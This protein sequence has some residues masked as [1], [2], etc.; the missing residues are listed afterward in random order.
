AWRERLAE[1]FGHRWRFP[2]IRAQRDG[3]AS[4]TPSTN[5]PAPRKRRPKPSPP[6]PVPPSPFPP[7]PRRDVERQ[8]RGESPNAGRPGPVAVGKRATVS[9]G[10]PD[11]YWKPGKDFPPGI[12][13]MWQPVDIDFPQGVVFLNSEHPVVIEQI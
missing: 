12:L 6:K 3:E 10:T 13:A 5:L 2:M 11:F 4:L 1:R 7:E 8:D 9:G